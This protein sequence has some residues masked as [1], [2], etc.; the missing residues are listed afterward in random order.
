MERGSEREGEGARERG[1]EGEGEGASCVQGSATLGRDKAAALKLH[2]DQEKLLYCNHL[3][4]ARGRRTT[5][6]GG[7]R[8]N[9]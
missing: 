8:C 9:I 3:E 4:K 6:G 7:I 1:S 2:Q 5:R